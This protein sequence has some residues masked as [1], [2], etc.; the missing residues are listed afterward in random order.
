[1]G[2]ACTVCC[3][4]FFKQKTA[5]E[6]RIGDWSSDVCSSDLAQT[7]AQARAILNDGSR[8]YLCHELFL[9]EGH[10]R[11]DRCGRE[12]VVDL[13]LALELPDRAAPLDRRHMDIHAITG[14]HRPAEARLV[15]GDRKSTRLNSS[16]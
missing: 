10:G 8:M 14:H 12:L 13:H 5:F 16:H 2:F 6:M 9:S 1:M 15:D 7:L 4:F 11:E 3:F